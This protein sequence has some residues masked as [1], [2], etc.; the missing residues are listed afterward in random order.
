M[1]CVRVM[2]CACVCGLLKRVCIVYDLLCGGVWSA[3]CAVLC[4]C[5]CWFYLFAC[6]VCDLLCDGVCLCVDCVR[7][8][9]KR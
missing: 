8:L 2:C 6:G 1:V 7:V 5:A 3:V 9:L 4:L